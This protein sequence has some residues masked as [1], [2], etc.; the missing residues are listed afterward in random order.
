MTVSIW[1]FDWGEFTTNIKLV[2]YMTAVV[3]VKEAYQIY[4]SE[5]GLEYI[6]ARDYDQRV[7]APLASMRR[8]NTR[9]SGRNGSLL[10]DDDS[11]SS[12][13]L[14][15]KFKPMTPTSSSA[16]ELALY[17]EDMKEKH[18][19]GKLPDWTDKEEFWANHGNK[20]SGG[21]TGVVCYTGLKKVVL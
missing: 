13:N 5:Q 12:A 8:S 10:D 6:P 1:Q 16:P 11:T 7:F 20:I 9:A 2:G 15:S 14:D 21:R 4:R 18:P 3:F 19:P 17:E